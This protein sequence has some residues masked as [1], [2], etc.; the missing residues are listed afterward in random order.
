MV[1]SVIGRLWGPA[2]ATRV[3]IVIGIALICK[4]GEV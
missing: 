2:V 3:F 1:M 4:P